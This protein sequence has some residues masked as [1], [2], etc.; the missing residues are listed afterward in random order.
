MESYPG[1]P[2]P[3]YLRI[4][5]SLSTYLSLKKAEILETLV[6]GAMKFIAMTIAW[7]SRSLPS[8]K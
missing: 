1:D 6:N 2:D 3:C 8:E 4:L 7:F 5:E